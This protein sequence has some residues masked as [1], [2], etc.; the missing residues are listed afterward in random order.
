MSA[1]HSAEPHQHFQELDTP[2]EYVACNLCG[3]DDVETVYE[4]REPETNRDMVR[5]F[6]ASG[7]ELLRDRLVRCR[8]CGLQYVNPRPRATDIV[9]AYSAGDDPTYVSQ[10]R[11]RERTF[12][13][14]ATHIERLLPG[15]GRL[16]DV[17]TAA[18]AFLSVARDRGWVVDGCEPNR[19]TAAWGSNHYGIQ[20]R[21]GEVFDHDFPTQ[22]YDVVPL[23]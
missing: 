19:W 22:A 20:I 4:A 21:I 15:R 13:R 11:A 1:A 16:L 17:G 8:R 9:L 18:G 7:D 14:A 10:V 2:F 3:A 23:W 12:A 5:T 6:R